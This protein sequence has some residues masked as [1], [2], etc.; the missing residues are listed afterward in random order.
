MIDDDDDDDDNKGKVST[1]KVD[2]PRMFDED[3]EMTR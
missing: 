2:G 3:S 1:G